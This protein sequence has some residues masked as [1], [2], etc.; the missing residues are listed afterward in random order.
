MNEESESEQKQ[1]RICD[2]KLQQM[3]HAELQTTE[4]TNAMGMHDRIEFMT[5]G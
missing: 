3:G 4:M 1:L 2:H 5:H